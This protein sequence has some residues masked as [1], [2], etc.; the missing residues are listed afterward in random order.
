MTED[1]VTD[2]TNPPTLLAPQ[3]Y[4]DAVRAETAAL[5]VAAEAAGSG[6]AVPS[7]PDWT[8][9][10]LLAHIGRVQNW[11]ASVIEART[12]DPVRF[13]DL[14]KPPEDAAGRLA[15]VRAGGPRLADAL[16]AVDPHTPI[17]TFAT[18]GAGAGTAAF[19]QRRQAHEAAVHRYDA[20][21][22]AGTPGPVDGARAAD[23]L[24]EL[25]TIMGPR[26]FGDGPDGAPATLHLHC[27][28]RDGE[29]LVR[30][31]AGGYEV[32]RV[33]AKGDVAVRGMASDLF[34]FAANRRG[35]DGLEVFG[36][37][38]VL[39]RWREVVRL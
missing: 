11:A 3:E 22:A 9:S 17:W 1:A 2:A 23:G 7:C 38:A 25:L 14:E 34:L 37:D 5:V 26:A 32:E 15:Y 18:E 10:D 12:T 33:H 4:A 24:D 6:A 13:R 36:D 20:E 28:D 35:T 30:F 19:W 16:A 27:T 39:A 31:G 8:V 21:L 29:W